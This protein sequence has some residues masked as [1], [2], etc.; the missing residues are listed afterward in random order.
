[1]ADFTVWLMC[2]RYYSVT[3]GCLFCI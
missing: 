1:M 2:S 3:T